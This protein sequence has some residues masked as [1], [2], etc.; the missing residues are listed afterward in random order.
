M[1]IQTANA[2]ILVVSESALPGSA[3][4]N[5]LI[6]MQ[7]ANTLQI[8]KTYLGGIPEVLVAVVYGSFSSGKQTP[9][10]DID[11]GVAGVTPFSLEFMVQLQTDLSVKTGREIDLIDLRV[12]TGTVLKQALT[13]GSF[14]IHRDMTLLSQILSRM[15]TDEADFERL[16]NKL[17]TEKRK[18]VFGV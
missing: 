6:A 15:V 11:L 12:A 17:L 4:W 13:Q 14:M 5:N 2:L 3:N 1:E 7:V 18:K 16:R 9:S 8:V 10:S